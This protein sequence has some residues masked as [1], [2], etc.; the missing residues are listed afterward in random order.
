MFILFILFILFICSFV[1]S[2]GSSSRSRYR[3]FDGESM[4]SS[5]RSTKFS[6]KRLLPLGWSAQENTMVPLC[7]VQSHGP[8]RWYNRR[9]AK[10]VVL[11]RLVGL[12][13]CHEQQLKAQWG[14]VWFERSTA[15][16]V[17]HLA[18]RCVAHPVAHPVVAHPEERRAPPPRA[19]AHAIFARSEGAHTATRRRPEPNLFWTSTVVSCKPLLPQMSRAVVMVRAANPP[20]TCRRWS[21]A[22]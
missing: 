4:A 6:K 18:T 9:N 2:L 8:Q 20:R 21:R 14:N 5:L 19:R 16:V 22:R 12:K 10:M 17:V 7:L 1:H 15:M 11:R 3:T 13:E